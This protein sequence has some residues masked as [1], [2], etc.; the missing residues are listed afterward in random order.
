MN[1]YR[2]FNTS[3]VVLVSVLASAFVFFC[4]WLDPLWIFRTAPPWVAYTQGANLSMDRYMRRAKPLRVF[5]TRPATV[6]LGSSVMYRGFN[7]EALGKNDTYN[8]G[9]SSLMAVELPT[10]AQLIADSGAKN[11]VIGLD[12]FMFSGL[13]GIPQVDAR[14]LSFWGRVDLLARTMHSLDHFS[15][16]SL[17]LKGK[18]EP[19]AWQSSG[20]KLT[21]PFEPKLTKAIHAAQH[22]DKMP[23]QPASLAHL[24]TALK[25]LNAQNI[26]VY[27]SPITGAQKNRIILGGREAEFA[28]W[29]RDVQA[30]MQEV[31]IPF[32]DFSEDHP[33]DDFDP[34]KGSSRYW[35]DN[36][37]LQPE[38]GRWIMEQ[39]ADGSAGLLE[40]D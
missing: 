7:P 39:W 22:F 9:I 3:F 14:F 37:H 2:A 13:A 30:I 4:V 12:Y 25:T 21:P 20:Y 16:L 8:L 10:F 19:G 32:R 11:V 31:K 27:L 18:T 36:L 33:F 5:V 23:Y 26:V 6:W 38:V 34:E 35:I 28:Q 24:R 40:K 17:T 29:R 15:E 1:T